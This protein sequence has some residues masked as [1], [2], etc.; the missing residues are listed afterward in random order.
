MPV[1]VARHSNNGDWVNL[2]KTR[3]NAMYLPFQTRFLPCVPRVSLRHAMEDARNDVV[4]RRRGAHQGRQG[5]ASGCP[6]DTTNA[7]PTAS[8]AAS[9][10][11]TP[12]DSGD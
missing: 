8:S 12:G 4:A 10:E 3:R 1:I 5:R 11:R 9:I 2:H 7:D 6:R